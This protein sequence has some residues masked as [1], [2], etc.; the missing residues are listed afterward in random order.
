MTT[1]IRRFGAP[2]G[3]PSRQLLLES[4]RSLE[5]SSTS[6]IMGAG[7]LQEALW[8][9]LQRTQFVVPVGLDLANCP[10]RSTTASSLDCA[11]N[12]P[13]TDP[14]RSSCRC[15]YDHASSEH[16]IRQG[17]CVLVC[18][19]HS[20]FRQENARSMSWMGIQRV[21]ALGAGGSSSLSAEQFGTVP[22]PR[23]CM[24]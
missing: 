18:S 11:G 19:S 12:L 16:F 24:I 21:T 6:G 1:T 15:E 20:D 3:F 22:G 9:R 2:C 8:E 10:M 13:P 7:R 14:R 4:L 23:P 5:I 17:K